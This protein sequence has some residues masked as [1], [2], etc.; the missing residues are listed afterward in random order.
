MNILVTG[1]AGFIGSHLVN[2]L[3]NLGAKIK[4]F[5]NLTVGKKENINEKADF[6]FGDIRDIELFGKAVE[7]CD[8]IFHLAAFTSVPESFSKENECK[9]VNEISF[10]NILSMAAKKNVKKIIF[11]S[12]SAVYP[13]DSLGPFNEQSKV[14]PSSPY[15]QSKLYGEI[16]LKHWCKENVDRASSA[17]RYFNVFGPRQEADS[18]YASVIPKFMSRIKNDKPIA[19][20]GD[21]SQTRD[22]IFVSDIAA[23]NIGV[24]ESVGFNIY[25]VGTG[26]EYSV[27]KLV[28]EILKITNENVNIIHESL[29]VGDALRSSA[30]SSFLKKIGWESKIDI[31]EGLRLTWKYFTN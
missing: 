18:D 22:Y 29:P 14:A 27:N 9:E 5:D 8:V 11:S 16:L 24:M 12:S 17:L 23:A 1:G 31:I 19:I 15:G 6:I 4:I 26:V 30:D 20:Y 28:E 21:G 13:D 7:N 2:Q 25:A 3:I 10:K